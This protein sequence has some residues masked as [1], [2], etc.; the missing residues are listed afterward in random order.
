MGYMETYKAWCEN[1]YFD[2]D[3]RA[4]L[5]SIAGDEK[6]IEDRF[7]KDLEFGTGGLRGV[8]GNGTNRMNVYIVRKATQGLAN[9]IIKEGTQDKGVAISHDNRR[10]SR[11]FA[12]EAA[13]CLAANGIKVYIFPSLRPTPELSFAVRELHCTAGIMVTA[14]LQ[15]TMDIRYTGMTD[16]R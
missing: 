13:L 3:T 10:M 8:I 4:E 15:N 12:Q 9:F 5:K 16:A 2:E 6:E 11:E 7:Y 14:S 1:E